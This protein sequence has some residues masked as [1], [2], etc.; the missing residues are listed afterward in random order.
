[1]SPIL[2]RREFLVRSATAGAAVGLAEL[3]FALPRVSA[4]EAKIAPV[5]F[6]SSIEPL[7]RLLEMTPRERV[8][9]EVASRI[10]QGATYREVLTALFLA[11]VRNIEPRP[12]GFKFHAVLVVNSAHLASLNSSDAD[13]WLPIFWAL[14][15]FKRSQARD[16]EE[17]DW[18]LS[19]VDESAVPGGAQAKLAFGQA[20][21]SW[22]P[23]AADA[24]IAGLVRTCAPREVFECLARYGARDFRDIGHKAIYLANGWRTLQTIGWEQAEPVLRS[25]VY[26]MLD[27]GQGNP[28]KRDD[29]ADRPG[30]RNWALTGK[31][32]EGWTDGKTDPG[33][34]S[35][36]LHELRQAGP[37]EAADKVVELLNAGFSPRTIWDGIFQ[38]AAELLM[39]QPGIVSL[40]SVT[41][42]NAMHFAWEQSGSDETRRW[43]LLQAV[44]FLPLFRESAQ[45][46][47]GVRID[48]LEA[49]PLEA[50][51]AGAVEEIF[52]EM[53]RDRRTAAR[54]ALG[55]LR[56]GGAVHPFMS[57]A[58]RLIYLKGIDSHDYKFSEAVL[59][60]YHHLAPESRARFLAASAFYLRGSGAPDNELVQRSREALRH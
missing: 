36:L 10:R 5:Q 32:R 52:S 35:A 12:V 37:V 49:A 15:Q 31:I 16:V 19:A 53:S 55:Y 40:H 17:G 45:A 38:S 22:D 8:L 7:V 3:G 58:R 59:E 18:T 13:R 44:S 25:V 2:N 51:G 39:R 6:D 43:L 57:T 33:A 23:A 9:E 30:R 48:E 26:A 1:M 4:A 54:K 24:A 47:T 56:S 34:S 41:T 29:P 42:S 11:G 60:D 28:G 27:H 21:N 14:D 20:M 46:K 50:Q